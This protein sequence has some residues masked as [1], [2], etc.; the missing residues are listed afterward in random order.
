M[1]I[2]SIPLRE[3]KTDIKLLLQ[4]YLYKIAKGENLEEF[5][6]KEA[7][8]LLIN[9]NW[10]GNIRELVKVVEYLSTIKDENIKI[11]STYLPRY[12][13]ENSEMMN[14]SLEKETS[15]DILSENEIWVLKKIHKYEGI[16][17]RM[18]SLLS[19]EENVH[20]GEGK[21]RTIMTKLKEQEYI[22]INKGLK[23]TKILK[24]G[25]DVIEKG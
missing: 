13:I 18:L 2:Y 12:I 4:Y 15:Y 24:K 22:E 1:P 25:L 5:F 11:D 7:I 17:R 23:G 9:Y 8:E 10:P 3:R 21:I 16:G 20:L 6:T 19:K 14:L